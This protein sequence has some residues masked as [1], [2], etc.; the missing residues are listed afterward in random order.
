MTSTCK[1]C[2]SPLESH[3]ERTP[4]C[5]VCVRYKAL[6]ANANHARRGGS[7]PG[8][9]ISL[10]QFAKWFAEQP[11]I[12]SFCSIP[13]GLIQHLDLKTQVG[14][15][16][17]RLGIDRKSSD[18]G[19]DIESIHLCCFACNKARSNT[20]SVAEMFAIGRSIAGVWSERLAQ[21]GITW[22]SNSELAEV[23]HEHA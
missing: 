19:Y 2:E 15:P 9:T 1:K 12:C 20:F 14:L 21:K 10:Q 18:A 23:H 8:V 3:T 22:S 7:S 16:L 6:S 13:E 17:Q 4:A 5:T 11:R